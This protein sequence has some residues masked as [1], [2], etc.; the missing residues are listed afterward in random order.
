MEGYRLKTRGMLDLL[1]TLH[2]DMYTPTVMSTLAHQANRIIDADRC[3]L[4]LYD[5]VHKSLFQMQGAVSIAV[6]LDQGFAGHVI[7]T[8]QTKV[9]VDAYTD[10]LFNPATDKKSGY[11][12]KSML[13]IPLSSLMGIQTQIVGV[14]QF[15][16]K[17]SA[18]VSSDASSFSLRF[19]EEDIYLAN[20][21]AALVGPIVNGCSVYQQLIKKA[22]R[23]KMGGS[24]FRGAAAIADQD[25]PDNN[26]DGD[27]ED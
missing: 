7:S 12:T 20:A 18:E 1:R 26:D 4:Y 10:E 24:S 25:G 6:P 9:V 14:L 21:F 22:Q 5:Y 19:T 15:T 27:D 11:R 23:A 8:G 2:A 16:N 3:T 13:C 17:I